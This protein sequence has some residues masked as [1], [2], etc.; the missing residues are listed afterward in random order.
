MQRM[1][2]LLTLCLAA[3][4][5]QAQV[6]VGLQLPQDHF[7]FGESI[8]VAVR[9]TNFSGQTLRMGRGNSWLQF[10]LESK[11]GYPVGRVDDIPVEGDFDLENATIAT[12]R[13][14]LTPHFDPLK[15]DRYV[16]TAYVQV[17]GWSSEPLKA[18]TEFTVFSGTVRWEQPFGLPKAP[19]STTPTEIRRYALQQAIYTKEMRLYVR[20]ASEDGSRI[21]KLFQV[22][23]L[24]TF[25]ETEQQI[26]RLSRLHLLYQYGAR[27]F[28]YLV[29]TPD[30]DILTRQTHDY[31]GSSRPRL[32]IDE[33]G[34]IAVKGGVR[35][36]SRDDYPPPT[37]TPAEEPAA[38]A[39]PVKPA[40]D[41]LSSPSR[42]N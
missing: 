7:L 42:V 27:S 21:I 20:I 25:S 9:I 18:K 39:P 4:T 41:Q 37:S 36:P 31:N 3:L 24:L 34:L 1:L 40:A 14:D 2:A 5:A 12:K 19:G 38:S 15:Q 30:G 11:S 35:R 8:P 28:Y 13:I 33:D 23:P 29:I 6:A 22:G 32:W 10:T 16:I 17:P 26:D